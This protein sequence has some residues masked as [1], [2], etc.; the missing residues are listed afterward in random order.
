MTYRLSASTQDLLGNIKR[1][2]RHLIIPCIGLWLLHDIL[3]L[4]AN[5]SGMDS[6][7]V[8]VRNRFLSF[9]FSSSLPIQL[10]GIK[11]PSF[12]VLWF[13]IAL[14]SAGHFLMGHI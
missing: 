3:F 1:S 11:V 8:W 9:F 5:H 12:G 4:L 13:L 2:F 6:L 14:F 7:A 10:M